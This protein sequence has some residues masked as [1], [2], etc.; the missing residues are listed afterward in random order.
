MKKTLKDYIKIG[1][2]IAIIL[3]MFMP[4]YYGVRPIDVLLEDSDNLE[5]IFGLTLPLLVIIPFLLMLIFKGVLQDSAIRVL[6]PIFLIL[7]ILIFA[8]YCYSIYNSY[9]SW[10]FDESFSFSI[11]ILV[12][13]VLLLLNLKYAIVK[14]IQLE[15]IFLAIMAFPI[16][17]YFIFGVS[18]EISKFNYGGYLISSA[19]IMLYIMAIYNLFKNRNPI[20]QNQPNT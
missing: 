8:D 20:R 5:A 12:S 13:L 15:N 1:L 2:T 16:I 18:I 9:G 7:Y 19:F 10:V 14:S 3:G 6:K 11:A 17:L 4:Y